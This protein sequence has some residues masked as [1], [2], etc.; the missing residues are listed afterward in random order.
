MSEGTTE[1]IAVEWLSH[2]RKAR[3]APNPLYPAGIVINLA[4]EDTG[5]EKELPYPAPECGVW[6]IRCGVCGAS[7]GIT[8]AGRVDDPRRVTLRC[9]MKGNA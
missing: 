4:G 2:G 7:A 9:L 6:V 8:A 1:K 3:C 5:C